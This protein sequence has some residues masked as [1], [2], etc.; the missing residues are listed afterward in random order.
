M[1][2]CFDT[3]AINQLADD[4]LRDILIA[5]IHTMGKVQA[6]GV[7]LLEIATTTDPMRRSHLL[8]LLCRLARGHSPFTLPDVLLGNFARA[9]RTG[10]DHVTVRIGED[11]A[12]LAALL[13]T[14]DEI[15]ESAIATW[16]SWRNAI[17]DQFRQAHRDAR[18]SFQELRTRDGTVPRSASATLRAYTSDLPFV[19][20][21]T[22]WLYKKSTGT[23]LSEAEV[24]PFFAISPSWPL[25]LLAWAYGAYRMAL[26]S[27]HH[28]AENA[29]ALDLFSAA[30]LPFCD[31]FVTH[32][33]HQ[34]FGLHLI[35]RF[36]ANRPQVIGW[37]SFRRRLAPDL[38][39]SG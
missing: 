34:R 11:N 25:F 9:H 2:I 17:E 30:Y 14:P 18:P 27:S 10:A 21:V 4:P 39:A 7:N 28:G 23:E 15:D 8:H 26:Q 31:I 3:S 36:A 16:W 1:D 32:D 5:G 29:G 12:H 13:R 22:N 38:I 20:E 6:T 37:R 35:S 24:R 33:R 19:T